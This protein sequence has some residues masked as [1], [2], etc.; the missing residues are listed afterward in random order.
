M[1]SRHSGGF[2]TIISIVIYLMAAISG[3]PPSL[4]YFYPALVSPAA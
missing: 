1:V 2:K 4:A 3:T